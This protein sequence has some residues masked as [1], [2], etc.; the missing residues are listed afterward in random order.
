MSFI[1]AMLILMEYQ[2]ESLMKKKDVLV[3][4]SGT[5]NSALHVARSISPFTRRVRIFMTE[6]S[7]SPYKTEYS[8]ILEKSKFK[9]FRGSSFY[10]TV[11]QALK[12][13]DFTG[14]KDGAKKAIISASFTDVSNSFRDSL[15]IFMD[16]QLRGKYLVLHH[17][18]PSAPP[19]IQG[20]MTIKDTSLKN[21]SS[22]LCSFS[23]S[24]EEA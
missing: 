2:N 19:N 9:W 5:V 17:D 20:I 15:E 12:V 11:N 1:T 10:R 23:L 18:I 8:T 7:Y 22:G 13:N 3:I 24:F 4:N 16:W 21:W 14:L 6:N